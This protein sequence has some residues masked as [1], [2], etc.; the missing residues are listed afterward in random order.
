MDKT[1]DPIVAS[2]AARR[3]VKSLYP[4]PFASRMALREKRPLGD[5]FGLANFGVNHTTIKPGGMSALR[6]AHTTQDEFVYVISGKPTLVTD[7]REFDLGPGMCVGFRAGNGVAHHL[8]NRTDSDVTYLEFGD[9]SEDDRVSYPDDDLRAELDKD[10][11]WCFLH[12][13]GTSY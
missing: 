4:E 5:L 13:D 11:R 6:H 2:E 3:T 12:K 1:D 9:R 7:A 8:L 10:G